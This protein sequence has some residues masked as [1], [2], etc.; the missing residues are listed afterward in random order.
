MV[1]LTIK[2]TQA[3]DMLE[4]MKSHIVEVIYGGS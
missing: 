2:Q 4:D 1:K 3:L